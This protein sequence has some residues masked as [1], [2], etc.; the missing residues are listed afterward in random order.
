MLLYPVKDSI[1][2]EENNFDSAPLYALFYGNNYRI[3]EHFREILV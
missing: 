2:E 3:P 1:S